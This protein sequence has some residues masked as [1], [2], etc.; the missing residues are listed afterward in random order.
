MDV[1]YTTCL[2]HQLVCAMVSSR[3]CIAKH[4]E[5]HAETVIL[6]FLVLHVRLSAGSCGD[7]QI[8]IG[9]CSFEIE[10]AKEGRLKIVSKAITITDNKLSVKMIDRCDRFFHLSFIQF[11][12]YC[13]RNLACALG[14]KCQ[15]YAWTLIVIQKSSK[16]NQMMQR[17]KS[18]TYDWSVPNWIFYMNIRSLALQRLL[19]WLKIILFWF[20]HIN[21]T[22][23]VHQ[24]KAKRM[25]GIRSRACA[26]LLM[27]PVRTIWISKF[28]SFQSRSDFGI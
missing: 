20:V 12:R 19:L 17:L 25:G 21:T 24:W 2:L 8:W 7:Q 26:S 9:W 10:G 16:R 4:K 6:W 5:F 27:F 18:K 1:H 15:L 22:L 3:S 13:P 28:K 14:W 23:F 11:L